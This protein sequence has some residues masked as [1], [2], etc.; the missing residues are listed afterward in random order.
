[1]AF[2]FVV[3]STAR[4]KNVQIIAGCVRHLQTILR[5]FVQLE[6]TQAELFP[7]NRLCIHHPASCH[8]DTL[9]VEWRGKNVH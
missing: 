8:G 6:A 2:F 1:M 4:K 7:A 9:E 5:C 3:I